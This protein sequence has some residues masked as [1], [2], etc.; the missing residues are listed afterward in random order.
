MQCIKTFNMKPLRLA[1]Q[2]LR[3]SSGWQ[4]T[5]IKSFKLQKVFL[6]YKRALLQESSSDI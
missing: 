5:S 3:S 1:Y 4:L 2:K 6:D